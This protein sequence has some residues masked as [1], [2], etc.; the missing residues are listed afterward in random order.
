MS[1]VNVLTLSIITAFVFVA[2]FFLGDSSSWDK[3][4][5]ELGSSTETCSAE[6]DDFDAGD[7]AGVTIGFFKGLFGLLTFAGLGLP[8]WVRVVFLII[9]GASWTLGVFL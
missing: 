6:T 5:C 4:Q 3:L 1:N 7:V 8:V 9:L 2:T